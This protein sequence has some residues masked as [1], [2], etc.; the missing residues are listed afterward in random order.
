M[1]L[2]ILLGMLYIV[3]L[4]VLGVATLRKGHWVMF[5]VGIFFPIMWIIGALIA[6]TGSARAAGAV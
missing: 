1:V 5:I 6:P 3:A 2:W 4:V